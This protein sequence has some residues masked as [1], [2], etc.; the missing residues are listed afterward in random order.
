MF[1]VCERIIKKN[2]ELKALT[3]LEDIFEKLSI[4]LEDTYSIKKFDVLLDIKTDEKKILFNSND[5]IDFTKIK[6]FTYLLNFK[7]N[8]IYNIEISNEIN[9]KDLELTLELFS[10]TIYNK[11]LEQSID[12]LSLIDSVTGLHN[13]LYL[14]NYAD[15]ILNIANR[16]QKKIGFLKVSIDQFK[17]V[18][19]EFDYTIGDEVLKALGKTLS[20]TVRSSDIVLKIDGDEFLVILINVINEDNA[21]MIAAKLINNFSN[22]KVLVNKETSQILKK[23]ICVGV[24]VFPDDAASIDEVIKQADVAL[25]EAKNKG[26]SQAYKYTEEEANTIDF[27]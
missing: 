20:N 14:D 24:T 16:E 8:L 17:A 27:F 5:V 7:T 26:R 13:R 4:Y 25:Y 6:S 3:S 2:N 11:H 22:E 10:Q 15:N 23:T 12:N 1:E 9:S 21:I 18:I 19:D